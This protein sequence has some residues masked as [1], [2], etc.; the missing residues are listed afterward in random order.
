MLDDVAKRTPSMIPLPRIEPLNGPVAP[1]KPK[2]IKATPSFIEKRRA[3]SLGQNQQQQ[4]KANPA[5]VVVV[6]DDDRVDSDRVDAVP[7]PKDAEHRASPTEKPSTPAPPVSEATLSNNKKTAV[8]PPH[9]HLMSRITMKDLMSISAAP[10]SRESSRDTVDT[11]TGT[12]SDGGIYDKSEFESLFGDDDYHMQGD[13]GNFIATE[14]LFPSHHLD[15]ARTNLL[16]GIDSKMVA[17]ICG[18]GPPPIPQQERI[19][20]DELA[21]SRQQLIYDSERNECDSIMA[22]SLRAGDDDDHHKATDDVPGVLPEIVGLPMEMDV[23]QE[24]SPS[25]ECKDH[26][27]P[28]E[29]Q[30]GEN[31]SGNNAETEAWVES[32]TSSPEVDTATAG[33]DNQSNPPL[34]PLMDSAVIAS[35]PLVAATVSE[36]VP[37]PDLVATATTTAAAA[38]AVS[39]ESMVVEDS[40]VLAVSNCSLVLKTA[41]GAINNEPV[42]PSQPKERGASKGAKDSKPSSGT[43]LFGKKT[44]NQQ[45]QQKKNSGALVEKERR[46]DDTRVKSQT[47]IQSHLNITKGNTPARNQEKKVRKKM[48]SVI[49]DEA[50]EVDEAMDEEEIKMIDRKYFERSGSS[51]RGAS[52]KVIIESDEEEEGAEDEAEV[53]DYDDDDDEEEEDDEDDEDDSFIVDDSSGGEDGNDDY[54]EGDAEEEEDDIDPE[55]ETDDGEGR[56]KGKHSRILGKRKAQERAPVLLDIEDDEDEDDDVLVATGRKGANAQRQKVDRSGIAESVESITAAMFPDAGQFVRDL[57][58]LKTNIAAVGKVDDGSKEEEFAEVYKKKFQE[59]KQNLTTKYKSIKEEIKAIEDR[60]KAVAIGT[61]QETLVLSLE[62][63]KARIDKQPQRIKARARDV[64]DALAADFPPEASG[65]KM[66]MEQFL[67]TETMITTIADDL[68]FKSFVVYC[69]KCYIDGVLSGIRDVCQE[70]LASRYRK[71]EADLVKQQAAGSLNKAALK[72]E[73]EVME[74]DRQTDRDS[75]DNIFASAQRVFYTTAAR[76]CL[77]FGLTDHSGFF[78]NCFIKKEEYHKRKLKIVA[79]HVGKD[80]RRVNEDLKKWGVK[81]LEEA[82]ARDH[83]YMNEGPLP[84]SSYKPEDHNGQANGSL[85]FANDFDQMMRFYFRS[86]RAGTLT[87]LQQATLNR[88]YYLSGLDKDE[89]KRQAMFDSGEVGEVSERVEL[90]VKGLLQTSSPKPLFHH[91]FHS[92]WKLLSR[93]AKYVGIIEGVRVPIRGRDDDSSSPSGSSDPFGSIDDE[94]DEENDDEED[95]DGAEGEAIKTLKPHFCMISGRVFSPGETA[96]LLDMLVARRKAMGVRDKAEHV[97]AFVCSEY[98]DLVRCIIRM[99]KFDDAVHKGIAERRAAQT[100]ASVLSM[101]IDQCNNSSNNPVQVFTNMIS[102]CEREVYR[103]VDGE[104]ETIAR[105]FFDLYMS[106]AYVRTSLSTILSDNTGVS[107]KP[108]KFVYPI[109]HDEFVAQKIDVGKVV[110]AMAKSMMI[111]SGRGGRGSLSSSSPSPPAGSSPSSPVP[112]VH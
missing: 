4:K 99:T 65:A 28:E 106:T 81:N 26:H 14:I 78:T 11:P 94:E 30:A 53:D 82:L 41:S 64:M 70:M 24:S 16:M 101:T 5:P 37:N 12:P 27:N 18:G 102:V 73:R 111:S 43:S 57:L 107:D 96:C 87:D 63:L 52:K 77:V 75:M 103:F 97:Y 15:D 46:P 72:K 20:N 88:F 110:D 59:L 91:P 66:T 22:L 36:P 13:D 74:Q 33:T 68:S 50:M 49:D 79:M 69:L 90:Q 6:V 61:D 108:V 31:E 1:E 47:K 45:Q 8:E 10:L 93:K 105:H 98:A 42:G 21:I 56:V 39:S 40:A 89:K 29:N 48:R 112:S 17:A 32:V 76:L 86:I 71:R 25:A 51:R 83:D 60:N 54:E 7:A 62:S 100:Q 104:L 95:E 9:E 67:D 80:M 35:S 23:V 38:A 109:V 19:G 85:A 58:S 92:A 84:S 34:P 3:A 55:S 2:I 44:P